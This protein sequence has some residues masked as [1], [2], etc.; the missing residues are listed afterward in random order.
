MSREYL[1]NKDFEKLIRK[2]I[3]NKNDEDM[4]NE[5]TLCFYLLAENI[6]K[7]FNFRLI[8][9]EDALQE[10]VLIC[11]SKLFMFNSSKG[12]A[13]NWFTTIILNHYRQLYRSCKNDI[14]L[15][16]KYLERQEMNYETAEFKGQSTE[17]VEN[18]TYRIRRNIEQY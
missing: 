6:I 1:N 11:F 5:I 9:K 8:D 17:F 14:N 2:Y 10:G 12:K 13:F 15:K 18:I 3:K 4:K 7:A 16:K